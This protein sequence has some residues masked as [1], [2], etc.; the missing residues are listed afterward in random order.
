MT[1]EEID[2]LN[3]SNYVKASFFS[4]KLGQGGGVIILTRE[5][6]NFKCLKIPEIQSLLSEGE[7]EFCLA[8][9]KTQEFSFV[10]GC[11]YRSPDSTNLNNFFT[12]LELLL[13]ILCKKHKKVIIAGDFNIDVL[14]KDS[15]YNKFVNILSIYEMMY[16]VNF[17]TRVTEH[18]KTAIDNFITNLK[19]ENVR[20][21][22]IITHISDHDGQIMELL[23][24]KLKEIKLIRKQVRKIEQ[25]N[26]ETFCTN[27]NLES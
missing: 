4:R 15:K 25:G 13:D 20:T 11:I 27:L 16:L 21:T 2:L 5:Y 8:E 23:N 26:I 17:P 6:L 10:I 7:F 24:L 3:F 14:T 18:S 9:I 12:K 22:G 19:P 1:S